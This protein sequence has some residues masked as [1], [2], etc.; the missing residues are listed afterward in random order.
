MEQRPVMPTAR[1]LTLGIVLMTWTAVQVQAQTPV[2]TPS[3]VVNSATFNSSLSPS[4]APGALVTIFGSNLSSTTQ[5][6]AGP[7]YATQLPGSSTR[8]TF[9]GIPA[10]LLYIS[11]NQI[12]V[13]VPFEVSGA[14]VDVIVQNGGASSLPVHVNLVAQDP[15]IFTI[16][17]GHTPLQPGMSSIFSPLDWGR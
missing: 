7:N 16:Q 6:S 9:G 5:T 15:G 8:V 13:Q 4:V 11:P 10:P 2:I 14:G 17:G 12:N 1:W 3:G